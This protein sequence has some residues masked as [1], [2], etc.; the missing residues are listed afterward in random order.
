MN[1]QEELANVEAAY[2][3]NTHAIS[4]INSQI[5]KLRAQL[6]AV[7]GAQD[8]LRVRR[9]ELR[10]KVEQEE[11][12][13]ELQEEEARIQADLQVYLDL[14]EQIKQEVIWGKDIYDW[15]LQGAAKLAG[16]GRGLLTDGTGMG[17][18][19]SSIAWRRIVGSKKTL[20]ATRKQYVEEFIKELGI[21]EPQITVLPLLSTTKVQREVFKPII[22]GAHDDLIV[23]TNIETWRR[24]PVAVAQDFLDMGFDGVILDEAHHIKQSS[25]GTA[26]GF[27][28]LARGIPS[29]LAMT[30]TPIKNR[31]Q[32]IYSILHALYPKA[33]TSPTK[34][35][36]DYCINMG[37][38]RWRFTAYGLDNLFKKIGSFYVGRS[39]DDVGL[40]I[41]PPFTK[42][43]YLDWEGYAEQEEA[44]KYVAERQLAVLKKANKVLPVVDNLARMTIL[45]QLTAWPADTK[46]YIKDPETKEILETVQF[47]VFQSVKLDWAEELIKELVE[48]GQRVVLFS[49]FKNPIFELERR[50]LTN[51]VRVATITGENSKNAQGV[52]NDF[53]LK[54]ASKDDYK[55]DVL[56]ATY[57]TVGESVNL[58]AARH[59]I[60]F[61]RNWSP[62]G[63]QQATGRLTRLNSIDSATIHIP[64]INNTIDTYIEKKIIAPKLELWTEFKGA[65][66]LQQGLIE[67]LEE[68]LK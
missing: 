51:G 5:E 55:Y 30:G 42:H 7:K 2:T 6:D 53:D 59:G 14:A 10:N 15:Q 21:R 67:A 47:D 24:D 50:F 9:R 64:A 20:I 36:N 18:T 54:F 13:R 27:F 65:A 58:N 43:Y 45:R 57:G 38:N 4:E 56:L 61:D 8:K 66:A 41:P 16:A 11:R 68:S 37:Q 32:E 23:I 34:F 39:P 35:L 12:Q 46:V 26:Q 1:T 22:S 60:L 29:V 52:V 17:K 25:T 28:E 33:F 62:A 63:D 3:T 19:F 44:Y 48:E 49:M 40:K 31:P